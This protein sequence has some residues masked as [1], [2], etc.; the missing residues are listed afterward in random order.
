MVGLMNICSTWGTGK[1]IYLTKHIEIDVALGMQTFGN[2]ETEFKDYQKIEPHELFSLGEDFTLENN[3]KCGV[4]ID[5]AYAW[6]ESR[7]F[8]SDLNKYLSYI[9]MQSR[10]RGMEFITTEQLN[11]TIDIR[12]QQLAEINV[13]SIMLKDR[14]RYIYIFDN[15]RIAKKDL[16]FKDCAKFVPKIWLKDGVESKPF[17]DCYRTEEIVK[18]TKFNELQ[19]KVENIDGKRLNDKIG[20][21]ADL[22][23]KE[24][25]CFTYKITQAVI[26][27]FILRH[28][29]VATQDLSYPLY[30]RLKSQYDDLAV[31][32]ER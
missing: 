8:G 20:V 1:T 11:S 13:A 21:L 10:K 9:L 29:D 26:D 5:E 4:F 24:K 12:F 2:Y 27:D 17:W 28:N 31:K 16:L 25:G 30:G 23:H 19:S 3:K 15:L 18:P 6:L 22:F 7:N 32:K 14:F